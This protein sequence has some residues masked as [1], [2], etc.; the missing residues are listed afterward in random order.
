MK[1]IVGCDLH[2]RWQQIA[3]FDVETGEISEQKLLNGEGEAERFYRAL[4]ALVGIEAC[5]NSQWFCRVAP[6]S[7]SRGVDRGCGA[8]P[9][10]LC[11]PAEDRS[12]GCG[13]YSALAAGEPFSTIVDSQCRAAG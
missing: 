9:G 10:Q 12:A 1:T 8:D 4:P 7:G 6:G 11:A 5:G 2:P 13:P 3:V